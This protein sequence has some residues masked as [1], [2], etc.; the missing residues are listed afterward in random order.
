LIR[1]RGYAVLNDT[2]LN[3]AGVSAPVVQAN[4][5]VIGSLGVIM[6]ATR[7]GKSVQ[8]R[9]PAAVVDGARRLSRALGSN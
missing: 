2:E 6:P 8:Q 5:G 7:F 9:L 3:V 1:K 4:L